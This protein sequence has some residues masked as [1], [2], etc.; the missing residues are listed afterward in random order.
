MYSTRGQSTDGHVG[1]QPI[2]D[3]PG[4]QQSQ[5]GKDASQSYRG[6]HQFEYYFIHF[7]QICLHVFF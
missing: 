6:G 4:S 7:V 2:G 3:H 5:G 1:S